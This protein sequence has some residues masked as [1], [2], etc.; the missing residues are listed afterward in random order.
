MR[1]YRDDGGTY[2]GPFRSKQSAES[3]MTAIWD[4]VP[5]R[6]CTSG[7]GQARSGACGYSQLGIAMCPCGGDVD[8]ARYAAVC[9]DVR[10]GIVS[11]PERL[12]APLAE[13]MN[14]RAQEQ[15]FEDA[16]VARDRFQSLA[17]SLN[18][19]RHWQSLQAAG[20]LWVEDPAGDSAFI[21]QGR[22]VSSW[23]A[24]GDSPLLNMAGHDV[25]EPTQVP[26]SVA[27]QEEVQLVWRWL[28]RPGVRVIDTLSP[29][30]SPARPVPSLE[31]LA[32]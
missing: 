28:N 27:L 30:A 31:T 17:A 15:R 1:A 32:G 23:K 13:R 4:A 16:A 19:R 9:D 3:V 29:F 7:P 24:G 6:R 14:C 25:L 26:T 12:L 8:E 11:D 10:L 5:I 2:L 18:R 21:D 20:R 22:L